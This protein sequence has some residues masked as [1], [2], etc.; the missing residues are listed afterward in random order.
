MREW[1]TQ[2]KTCLSFPHLLK[3]GLKAEIRK[4]GRT[5]GAEMKTRMEVAFLQNKDT[6]HHQAP[7]EG[8]GASLSL[9]PAEGLPFP[10]LVLA[11]GLQN[12]DMSVCRGSPCLW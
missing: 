11:S 6:A 7:G 9:G 5:R 1:L 4:R 10:H 2:G 3:L 12:H 8:P